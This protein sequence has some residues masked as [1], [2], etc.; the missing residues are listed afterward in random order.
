MVHGHLAI[1]HLKC[2]APPTPCSQTLE[3]GGDLPTCEDIVSPLGQITKVKLHLILSYCLWG[4]S[5]Q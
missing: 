5:S 3:I 4:F 1:M 2:I